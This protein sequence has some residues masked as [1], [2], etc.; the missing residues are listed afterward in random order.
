VLRLCQ[1]PVMT[2]VRQ[3]PMAKE[4]LTEQ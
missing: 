3:E 2:S 1:C 4:E